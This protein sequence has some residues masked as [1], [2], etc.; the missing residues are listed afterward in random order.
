MWHML[1]QKAVIFGLTMFVRQQLRPLDLEELQ[2]AR[3]EL[4]GA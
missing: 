1:T 3:Y 2:Q 4:K